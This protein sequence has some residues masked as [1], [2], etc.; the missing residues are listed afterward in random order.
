MSLLNKKE[1]KIVVM[2][3]MK[4]VRP[5]HKYT[6]C[7]AEFIS[8]LEALLLG[9]IDKELAIARRGGKTIMVD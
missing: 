3:R 8:H 5:N 9:V 1:T 7:S 4:V 2:E 6:Q